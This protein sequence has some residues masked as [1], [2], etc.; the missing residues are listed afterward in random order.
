MLQTIFV[1]L[2]IGLTLILL[3]AILV[4]LIGGMAHAAGIAPR[5]LTMV[6]LVATVLGS[7]AHMTRGYPL[8]LALAC[9][10]LLVSQLGIEFLRQYRG[11]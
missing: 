3:P 11:I 1:V 9:G 5:T 8:A 7:L 2:A 4:A 6:L 10:L